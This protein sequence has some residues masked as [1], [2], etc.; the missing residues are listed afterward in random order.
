VEGCP[1]VRREVLVCSRWRAVT[2]AFALTLLCCTARAE[3]GVVLKRDGLF[4]GRINIYER[5]KPLVLPKGYIERDGLFDD[6][7]VV[8]DRRGNRIGTAR[9]D[10]L[11][12]RWKYKKE[13]RHGRRHKRSS[14]RRH[15]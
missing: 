12:D 15:K 8:R 2:I 7:Y 13:K 11:S 9:R 14:N 5:G 1:L 3:D 4:P 6:E 10:R